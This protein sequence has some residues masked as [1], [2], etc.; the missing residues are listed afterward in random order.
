VSPN[1]QD[2]KRM[3]RTKGVTVTLVFQLTRLG[4]LHY[5]PISKRTALDLINDNGVGAHYAFTMIN[6]TLYI[7]TQ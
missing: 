5:L 2:V 1:G 4:G 3:I 7:R 6:D